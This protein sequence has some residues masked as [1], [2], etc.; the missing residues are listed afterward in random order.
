MTTAVVLTFPG[1]FFLTALT[2]QSIKQFYQD[3]N[4]VYV[5]YDD[6]VTEGWPGY[7]EDCCKLYQISQDRFV[8][9]S[10]INP[11]IAKCQIG[12]YR[13]QLIKCSVD[14]GVPGNSWFV[15]DG[16][17]IFDERV[18]VK[19]ITPVQHRD[20]PD[21]PLSLAVLNG[22]KT[23]LGID[24]HPL[25]ADGRFKI[26][27]SIPFRI[28]EKPVLEELRRCVSDNIGGDFAQRMTELVHSH[29]L[30]AYDETGNSMVLHEWELIEAVNHIMYP[31]RFRIIDIG[32]GYELTKDTA[33]CSSAR[34]RH[35]YVYS[36]Q[37]P[38][39]WLVEQVGADTVDRYWHKAVAYGDYFEKELCKPI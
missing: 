2:L 22:V 39:D 30:V 34:F 35:G 10:E 15:V 16:D 8:S 14:Q 37:L 21:D 6:Q 33:M 19:D 26:T 20:H 36:H 1:H 12:W 5:L 11:E 24:Q 28:L 17:I 4:D 23:L 3:I 29:K 18:D 25:L 31:G 13:Q 27:S 9:Y 7:V 32:S 38:R